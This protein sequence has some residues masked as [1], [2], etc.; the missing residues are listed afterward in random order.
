MSIFDTNISSY[1]QVWQI[2]ADDIQRIKLEVLYEREEYSSITP[3]Y[4][5][6]ALNLRLKGD[7]LLSTRRMLE[8][9]E[10]MPYCGMSEEI[11]HQED[12]VIGYIEDSIKNLFA[13]WVQD[14]GENPRLRLDRCLM[15]RNDSKA[16]LLEC[17]IDPNILD[18]CHE[19]SYWINLRFNIPVNIQVI[20]DKWSTLH[21]IYES[22]LAVALAY[23]RIIKG[24]LFSIITCQMV[25]QSGLLKLTLKAFLF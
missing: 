20:Y 23:N 13:K 15:R 5:G 10:W 4:A 22:V 14:V 12:I 9:A 1:C 11:Y 16:G 25:V 19:S 24:S 6:R 8:E 17:N 21:F 3:Y 2:F 18:L 7:R